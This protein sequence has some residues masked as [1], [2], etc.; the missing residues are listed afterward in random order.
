MLDTLWIILISLAIIVGVL[1][2][3]AYLTYLERKVMAYMQYRVGP[4]RVGFLG[5]LQPIADG[6]K[7][8]QKETIIP[9]KS[10]R[11]IFIFAPVFTFAVAFLSWAVIPF[12]QWMVFANLD[13]GILYIL[14]LSSL[15]VYGVLFAGWSS[16]S[17]YALMGTLR[18][19]AQIISYE[20]SMG[21][22][23]T[24][25]ALQS[26]SLNLISI[27][28]NQYSCWN[29]LRFFPIFIMFIVCILAETNRTP[30]DLSE[31]ESDIVAGYYVEYS[32]MSFA[33][34]FLS[35]YGSILLMS[36]L[37]SAVFLGG[38]HMPLQILNFIPAPAVFLLKTTLMAFV[39]VWVRATLPRYRYDQ[40]MR[41]NWQFFI[42]IMLIVL[43]VT[44]NIQY[45]FL[46]P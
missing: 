36:A 1:L 28:E 30:F 42:P 15:A 27:V 32:S 34:F 31:S 37:T 5:L 2:G 9:S 13:L 17:K 10:N 45:F 12:S 22:I 44:I 35:E 14:A 46:K 11:L 25:I 23:L 4:N 24:F 20:L 41:I 21:L 6:L 3:A 40:L 16:N 29:A 18:A 38:W 26:S 39:F 8:L 7:L 43:F 19:A 33:L